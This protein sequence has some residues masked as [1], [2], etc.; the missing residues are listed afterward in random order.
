MGRA[1]GWLAA[2]GKIAGTAARGNGSQEAVHRLA[3]A[4]RRAG[5]AERSR[6][7]SGLRAWRGSPGRRP[8]RRRRSRRADHERG[9]VDD[10]AEGKVAE[11]GRL[12]DHVDRHPAPRAPRRRS[13]GRPG[14]H[15]Q[16][17]TAMAAPA[18]SSARPRRRRMAARSRRAA[19]RSPTARSCSQ[20]LPRTRS[21]SAPA[22][23]RS[24]AVQATG[25]PSPGEHRARLPSSARKDRQAR[26]SASMAA[27]LHR[28]DGAATRTSIHV[29]LIAAGFLE[30][31][32]EGDRLVGACARRARRRSRPARARRPW[33]CAWRRRR[34][35]HA[36][37][38]RATPTGR[39][40]PRACGPARRTFRSPSR[41]QA[42]DSRVST[43]AAF[44]PVS[45][46]S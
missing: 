3:P 40:R 44:M 32:D 29:L 6:A 11:V 36:R 8:V 13:V 7:G 18:E 4:P 30:V 31:G 21:T 23:E 46:S 42:S 12:V 5:P 20:G 16:P 34:H 35:T 33:P 37:R 22:A 43:P 10:G 28:R 45:S 2:A 15:R 14:R 24:S 27:A 17:P 38:R 41:D 39:G 26:A 1:L 9:A 19:A 25:G